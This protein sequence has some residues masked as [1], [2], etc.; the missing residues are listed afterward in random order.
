VKTRTVSVIDTTNK[1]T[2]KYRRCWSCGIYNKTT[3]SAS[4]C[5]VVFSVLG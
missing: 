1:S 3:R 4:S 5:I 2:P